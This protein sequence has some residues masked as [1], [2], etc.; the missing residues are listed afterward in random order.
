MEAIVMGA[1]GAIFQTTI[2]PEMQGR[3]FALLISLGRITLPLGLA[4]AG[5]VADALGAQ[6]WYLT[7]G[8]V[9][10]VTGVAAFFVPAIMG[11]EEEARSRGKATLNRP[12]ANL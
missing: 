6:V 2:P 9:I 8:I 12:E 1:N 11:I 10:T 4:I 7:A 3:V 5:P